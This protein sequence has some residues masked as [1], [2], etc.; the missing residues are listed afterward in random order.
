MAGR[1]AARA[2]VHRDERRISQNAA[3][4]L[5]GR[6][7]TG[8][9][10]RPSSTAFASSR[11]R[12]AASTCISSMSRRASRT[13]M[14]LLISHGWPG[15]VFEFHKLI[16][17]L[18]EHFTV[19]APSLPGYTLSFKPGQKRFSVIEIAD[20]F[21]ELMSALGYERSACR[22]ATGAASSPR[23]LG[24]A[25]PSALTGIHINLLAVRRDPEKM[26]RP[27][28][29][30][31][32]TCSS[33]ALP[34]GGDRLPVDPGHA[35]ADTSFRAHRLAGRPRCLDRGEVPRLDRLRRQSGKRGEPRRDAGQHLALLVHR[36]DRRVVLA[37]L[38]AHARS[39][40][41]PRR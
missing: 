33:S 39:L 9:H 36:R 28:P 5:A 13:P 29:R 21:A 38:R 25:F 2:V 12:S 37:V 23:C 19:V 6:G 22:A 18:T 26:P 4:L 17:L 41:D 40:A 10:G 30:K 8:A 16:P 32:P 20:I 3:R 34:Q 11:C 35:A 7:S 15:S 14:P 31:K 24:I 27:T 1:A